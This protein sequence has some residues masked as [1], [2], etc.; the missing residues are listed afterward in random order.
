MRLLGCFRGCLS[1]L[2]RV[3]EGKCS[4]ISGT[5]LVFYCLNSFIPAQEQDSFLLPL[6]ILKLSVCFKLVI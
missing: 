6:T 2:D 4:S 1:F 5:S 3:G